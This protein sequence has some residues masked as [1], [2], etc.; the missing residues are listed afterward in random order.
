MTRLL[1]GSTPRDQARLLEQA[2]SVGGAFMSVPP[3]IHLHYTMPSDQYKTLLRWWLGVP[4]N[5]P[6]DPGG[7]IKCPGCQ[8]EIDVFGDHLLCCR[9]NNFITRHMAVQ[10]TLAILLQ[11]GGQGVTKEVP[12][13]LAGTALRPADLL[14]ANWSAGKD[15]AIDITVC[16]AWQVGEQRVAGNINQDIISRERW[17]SFLKRKETDK[18]NKYDISCSTAGWS[19]SAM[20]FGT[21]GGVG[22]ECAKMLHQITKRAASWQEGDLRASK[23]EQARHAVG[24]SLMVKVLEHMNNKNYLG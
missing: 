1:D 23:T 19:F 9:R 2:N 5:V 20:A 3:N 15:T 16:H 12:I 17:R 4:L 21:W 10:D 22:P 13:P 6:P 24:W 18:H 8:A 11:E 7:H 14:V